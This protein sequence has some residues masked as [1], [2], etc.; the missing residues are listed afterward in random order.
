RCVVVLTFLVRLH[1][2]T[3]RP[4]IPSAAIMT[5]RPML[6]GSGF[7]IVNHGDI[8]GRNIVALIDDDQPC[9]AERE[10][11]HVA[12][13]IV[14]LAHADREALLA[15]DVQIDYHA[16]APNYDPEAST[17]AFKKI[18]LDKGDIDAGF[19]AADVIV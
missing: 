18:A 13:P 2:L 4:T 14:L 10:V 15:A 5:V 3:I 19:R 11:R 12:E 16:A 7:T 9:L 1:C 6:S 17:V 8:P